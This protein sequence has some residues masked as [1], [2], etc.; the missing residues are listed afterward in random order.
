MPKVVLKYG[1][2]DIVPDGGTYL[3]TVHEDV[4]LASGMK[5]LVWHYYEFDATDPDIGPPPMRFADFRA[6][7]AGNAR[8]VR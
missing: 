2:A 6:Q 4:E 7:L 3:T 8:R 1:T 5:R